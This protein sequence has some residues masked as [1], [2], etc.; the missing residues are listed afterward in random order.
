MPCPP[1]AW[2]SCW[3]LRTRCITAAAA[4]YHAGKVQRLL[5][6]GDNGTL[7]YNEPWVM[8]KALIAAGV[9]SSHIALDHAGFR[10]LDSMVR[11]REVFGLSEFVVISQ[12][13]HVERA[14]YLAHAEGI[15]AVGFCAADVD[16]HRGFRTLLREYGARVKVFVD[17]WLGTRPRFLGEPLPIP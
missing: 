10:T 2:A 1:C 3:A 16:R 11:A 6:S 9:D 4:L 17:H 5:L 15:Q 13:F 12:R 8:R 14:V 7:H